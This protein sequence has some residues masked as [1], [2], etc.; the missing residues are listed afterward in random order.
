M[1]IVHARSLESSRFHDAA[2][3]RAICHAVNAVA[4]KLEVRRLL[5]GGG[6]FY[7]AG[8]DLDYVGQGGFGGVAFYVDFDADV[9]DS[10]DIR[11]VMLEN[12]TDGWT[13]RDDFAA[14]DDYRRVLLRTDGDTTRIGLTAT[15]PPNHVQTAY[16]PDGNYELTV[17]EDGIFRSGETTPI[18]TEKRRFN[19]EDAYFFYTGDFDRNREV[20]ILDW[21]I[22]RANHGQAGTF[23]TG[24]ANG[25]GVVS[26]LD[27]CYRSRTVR[28]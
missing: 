12:L 27:L 17:H 10:I 26:I 8:I 18:G 6:G 23:E 20:N 7:Q 9:F 24:D 1:L 22:L 25:D 28:Q 3:D 4:E 14:A 21:A 19:D 5:S 16:P 11:D 2:R 15:L 13:A